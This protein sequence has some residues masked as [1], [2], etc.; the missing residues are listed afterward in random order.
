[1]SRK[2]IPKTSVVTENTYSKWIT[3]QKVFLQAGIVGGIAASTYLIDEGIAELQLAYPEYATIIT[4]AAVALVAL[5]NYLKH[6]NDEQTVEIDNETGER[7]IISK[8]V[9]NKVQKF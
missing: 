9:N 3:L 6:H 4:L 7:R 2:K 1:M 8:T 5:R